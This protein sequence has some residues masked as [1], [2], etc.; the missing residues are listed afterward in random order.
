ML[1]SALQWLSAIFAFAAAGLWLRS[2]VVRTPKSFPV[3]VVKPDSFSRPLGE[4]L[5]AT[6]VGHG[7][8]PALNELGEA[9]RTQS[10]WSAAAAICAA[11]SAIFQA[12]VMVLSK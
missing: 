7:H 2:A 5:G 3:H 9:L 4:P 1:N 11:L 10:R 8:S 6:Y 12:A